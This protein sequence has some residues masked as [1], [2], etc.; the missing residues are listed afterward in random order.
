MSNMARST[1]A[2]WLQ[3]GEI[4]ARGCFHPLC[5]AVPP[6]AG[7]ASGKSHSF[8]AINPEQIAAWLLCVQEQAEH[9]TEINSWWKTMASSALLHFK[10]SGTEL[11]HSQR[12]L[13]PA[14]WKMSGFNMCLGLSLT[15]R[16]KNGKSE[17]FASRQRIENKPKLS[18]MA[19]S[20]HWCLYRVIHRGGAM[21]WNHLVLVLLCVYDTASRRQKIIVQQSYYFI[22]I[23]YH[24]RTANLW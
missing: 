7:G 5:W 24:H 1:S 6:W 3:A 2:L 17:D 20:C 23:P 14:L 4:P 12:L 22:L 11:S 21:Q 8:K 16:I 10:Q 13:W 9:F 19:K 18:P 15:K